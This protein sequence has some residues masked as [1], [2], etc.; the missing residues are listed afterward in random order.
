[1]CVRERETERESLNFVHSYA[2]W[3]EKSTRAEQLVIEEEMYEKKK[4]RRLT[5][6]HTKKLNEN[7]PNNN[8][9]VSKK[10]TKQKNVRTRYKRNSWQNDDGK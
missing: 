9:F 1:M 6:I 7:G 4:R 10:R 5:Y 2:K 3:N 8:G